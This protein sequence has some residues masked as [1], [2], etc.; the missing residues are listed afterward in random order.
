MDGTELCITASSSSPNNST[1]KNCLCS[2]GAAAA[3]AGRC[4]SS[5][6]AIGS[7]VSGSTTWLL[8][9]KGCAGPYGAKMATF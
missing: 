2:M 7:V 8:G 3:V 6:P 1:A 5:L 4:L 9:Q